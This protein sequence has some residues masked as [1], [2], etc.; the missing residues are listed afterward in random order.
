MMALANI[1]RRLNIPAVSVTSTTKLINASKII[2]TVLD[3]YF[4]LTEKYQGAGH[5]RF[6]TLM[7]EG[8]D[9]LCGAMAFNIKR[10]A[11]AMKKRQVEAP[12]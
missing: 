1:Y 12:V 9:H 5:A 2:L 4:G 3:P 7:K 6:P 8:W 10:V 11:L